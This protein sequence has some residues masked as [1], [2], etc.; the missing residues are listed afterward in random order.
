MTVTGRPWRDAGGIR[1]WRSLSG[2]RG[3]AG[4]QYLAARAPEAGGGT[5]PGN[6]TLETGRGQSPA[7]PVGPEPP[8]EPESRFILEPSDPLTDRLL[9]SQRVIYAGA[10]IVDPGSVRDRRFEQEIRDLRRNSQKVLE[11]RYGPWKS[12]GRDPFYFFWYVSAPPGIRSM[13]ESSEQHP[14]RLLGYT[15]VGSCPPRES[16]AIG[17]RQTVMRPPPQEPA[18]RF[19][20]E[21]AE[22]LPDRP[23]R[24]K[25]RARFQLEQAQR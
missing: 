16:D 4:V 3:G 7:P 19:T 13:L 6:F 23:A 24:A 18:S 9:Q 1:G 10:T 15:A 21:R 22:P 11:C 8:Q 17:Y 5:P 25:P 14:L 2:G 12:A 20:L